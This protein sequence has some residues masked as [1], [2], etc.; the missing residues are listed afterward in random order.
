[1][2]QQDD[3]TTINDRQFAKCSSLFF[4]PM[5]LSK[6]SSS[7]PPKIHTQLQNLFLCMQWSLKT[8]KSSVDVSII[9]HYQ[10]SLLSK[11][12]FSCKRFQ[13]EGE[14]GEGEE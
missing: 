4:V 2:A 6:K 13:S 10:F 8:T 1:M 9:Y 3:A 12:P 11:N 14:G 7:L 5:N